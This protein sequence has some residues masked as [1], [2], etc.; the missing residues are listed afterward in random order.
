MRTKLK[1]CLDE[2]GFDLLELKAIIFDM[3]G[4]LFDTMPNHAKAWSE[5]MHQHGINFYQTDAYEHEGR[6]GKGTIE[7][8]IRREL[9][10][11]PT[12]AEL[13]S[14][15][16]T[17]KK[18]FDQLPLGQ[19]MPGAYEFLFKIAQ[20]QLRTMI[21]TG[22]KQQSSLERI[23]TIY[24]GFF[25]DDSIVSGNDVRFGKPDPEPYCMALKKGG[26]KPN[27]AI[28]IENA[29]LGIQSAKGAG[30]FTIAV[31]TGPLS[32]EILYNA[33]ADCVFGSLSELSEEWDNL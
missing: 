17:K 20:G 21:V 25:T 3:D 7:Y 1:K 32:D 28:V 12:P 6:T 27:E 18:I 14:I 29:P 2:R 31:N 5:S 23:K 33:G 11:E 19:Q 26:L 9:Q 24:K 8:I 4:V 22:S 15:Y 10:R 13:D 30:I 16:S